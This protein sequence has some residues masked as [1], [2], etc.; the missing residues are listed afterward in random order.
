MRVNIRAVFKVISVLSMSFLLGVAASSSSTTK[1]LVGVV[2]DIT[3]GREHSMMPGTSDA[4]CTRGCV[5][6]LGSKYALITEDQ[7]LVLEGHW[8]EVD[9]LAGQKAKVTGEV[10]GQKI[11]VSRVEKF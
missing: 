10:D 8:Q 11:N 6:R 4:Q 9:Q 3:C 5:A 1:T 2:G 7:V